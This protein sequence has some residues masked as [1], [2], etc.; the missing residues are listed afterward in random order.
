MTNAFERPGT[1]LPPTFFR[2]PTLDVCEDLLG[3]VLCR[4]FPDGT[5]GR[6]VIHEVEAYDGF[7]DKASHAHRGKTP[8]NEIMFSPGGYWYVYLCYGVHWLLNIVTERADYPGAVLIRGAGPYIGPGRLTKGIQVGREEHATPARRNCGL[9]IESGGPVGSRAEVLLTPRVGI[10]S[11][12]PEWAGM[13][14]RFVL[15]NR[16][17]DP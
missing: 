12:G 4:R 1:V 5:T 8:R 17:R 2:R 13:P 6:Y 15:K 11:A 3:A 9:W 16:T 14:W 10:D 7:E